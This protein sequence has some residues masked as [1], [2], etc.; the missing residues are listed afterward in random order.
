MSKRRGLTRRELVGAGVGLAT[1]AS[2]GGATKAI[3]DNR[4]PAL[5]PERSLGV[6]QFSIRD[7]ITR[8]AATGNP[9]PTMGYLGGPDF[10]EDP[11]DLGPLTPLPGGFVEVFE[12][13]ASV[14]YRG[15][16][17]FQFS[18]GA[19][20]AITPE[21][22]RTAL[23][24]AGLV[25]MGTHTGGLGTMF[26]PATN[27][28]SAA[29]QAQVDL[30]GVLGHTMIGTAGDPSG[31]TTLTDNPTN[32]N[33][34]GWKEAARRANIVGD[35]LKSQ[36]LKYYFH[37]EQNTFRLFDVGQV[38]GTTNVENMHLIQWFTANTDPFKVFF[39]LDIL[40]S[41]SGRLR[42]PSRVTGQPDFDVWAW[43]AAQPK[44]FLAYHIKDGNKNPTWAGPPTGG[45]YTQTVQR[46]GFPI[47]SGTPP[48]PTDVIYS[49][50]GDLA[51][52]WPAVAG[53]DPNVVGFRKLF[54]V[55]GRNQR[56]HIVESDS[57]PGPAA[58]DPGRSLRHAKISAK[59]L[60]RERV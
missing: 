32:P 8:L 44:R 34:I 27:G 13:L 54:E 25:S 17:F 20:G 48:V 28:L 21:Q 5:V 45:P 47:L 55:T 42:F 19:N 60:A 10:P 7:A 31:R 52:G 37:P 11:D 15:I 50:E 22:I 35:I 57:G 26:D 49:M 2:L 51:K 3:G 23:D 53:L 29:G 36:G 38:D 30:A 14:G 18:Q 58:I 40:H 39:E 4:G 12:F 6:Q 56:L 24:N 59:L 1:A 46:A 9:A 43:V 33:Q 41:Y 16:E